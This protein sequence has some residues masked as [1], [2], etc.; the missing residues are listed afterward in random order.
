M[1]I[2]NTENNSDREDAL[3]SDTQDEK[4]QDRG[5]ILISE[6]EYGREYGRERGK[7]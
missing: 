6:T 2:E 5:C 7:Q 3:R 4:W 1:T